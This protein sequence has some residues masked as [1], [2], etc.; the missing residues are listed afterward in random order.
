MN[1]LLN[2]YKFLRNPEIYK[3]LTVGIASAISTL[4]LTVFF[5]SI[6]GIFYVLSVAISLE[7]TLLWS[8]FVH[9]RWTFNNIQKTTSNRIRFIKYNLM[10]LIGIVVNISILVFF[11]TQLHLHYAVSETLAIIISFFFNYLIHKK[12]SWKN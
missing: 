7:S 4:S 12:I 8:Y 11:T 10:A 6:L 1:I 5:T 3:F 9:D 2:I